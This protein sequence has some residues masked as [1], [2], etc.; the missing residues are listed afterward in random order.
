M[1]DVSIPL[2]HLW[3]MRLSP[4]VEQ[5]GLGVH[6]RGVPE[7]VLQSLREL[8]HT[9]G[10]SLCSLCGSSL[11]SRKKKARGNRTNQWSATVLGAAR[12]RPPNTPSS[13][14]WKFDGHH[15]AQTHR[16][17]GLLLSLGKWSPRVVRD[18]VKHG[19]S[20]GTMLR[21]MI[22]VSCDMPDMF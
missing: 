21:R 19:N 22:C 2:D 16:C 9:R 7:E 10:S 6:V 1:F 17:F 13:V 8:L 3:W 12:R 18:R 15:A 4:L 11:R 20:C 14:Q 5:H